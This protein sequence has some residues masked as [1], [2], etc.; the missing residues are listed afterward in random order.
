MHK[1]TSTSAHSASTKPNIAVIGARRNNQG[2]GG[3]IA[4]H[5]HRQKCLIRAIL[6]TGTVSTQQA[7]QELKKRN[8]DACGYTDIDDLFNNEPIDLVVIATPTCHHLEYIEKS[9]SY[10]CN[11]FCEKPLCHPND[12]LIIGD[13]VSYTQDLL[14]RFKKDNLHLFI[15]TQWPYTIDA[16][17]KLYSEISTNPENIESFTMN[18]SPQSIGMT[19]LID[20]VP[21][22]LSMLYALLNDGELS[23]GRV[24][25]NQTQTQAQ[26]VCNYVHSK[27]KTAV[28]L[29]LDHSAKQPKPA[30]YAINGYN[31][32]R[33]I[34]M[35]DYSFSFASE[36]KRIDFPDPLELSVQNCLKNINSHFYNDNLIISGMKHL[37]IINK[38][39]YEQNPF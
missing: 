3:Y 32:V 34:D 24:S 21:H 10:G 29:H 23:Q 27:G 8:I 36:K 4:N 28:A 16:F 13:P 39:A 7:L 6:G 22:F 38:L 20:A 18:L 14:R 9:L 26:V 2:T 1:I 37:Y 17:R 30:S 31:L 19:M 33:H 25:F 11:V 15:N 12:D 5:F 35:Q